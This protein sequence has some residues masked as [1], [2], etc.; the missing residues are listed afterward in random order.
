[1]A[2][3]SGFAGTPLVLIALR[4][5]AGI[6][7][8]LMLASSGAIVADAFPRRELGLALG[9]NAMVIAVGSAIGPVLGGWLT[10]FSWQWVFW[11]NVPLGVHGTAAAVLILHDVPEARR[12]QRID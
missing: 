9:I 12:A 5:F 6:G 1:M 7:G 10:S 2:L 4:V 11:F 8:A 3:A